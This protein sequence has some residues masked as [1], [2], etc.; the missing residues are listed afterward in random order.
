MYGL[1]FKEMIYRFIILMYELMRFMILM[2][3]VI[4]ADFLREDNKNGGAWMSNF[5][6]RT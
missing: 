4:Y 6:S 1:T 2:E 3:N 5:V